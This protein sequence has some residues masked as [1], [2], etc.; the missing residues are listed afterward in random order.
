[1]E[2]SFAALARD[3]APPIDKPGALDE[4]AARAARASIV[5]IGEASHGTDDFYAARAAPTSTLIADHGFR[6]VALEA[7]SP[8]AFRV[9]RFVTGR[10][11]DKDAL[12]ALSDFRRFPAWTWRN[13]TMREFVEWLA[14]FNAA[15]ATHEPAGLFGLDL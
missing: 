1:M 5:L 4:L 3:A 7:D 10:T 8:D 6:A 11:D 9:H 2:H 15:R 12:A 14:D 13:E